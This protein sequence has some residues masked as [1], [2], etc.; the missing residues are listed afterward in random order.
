MTNR[1]EAIIDHTIPLTELPAISEK[2][3]PST[4][5][6][7]TL[8]RLIPGQFDTNLQENSCR[9]WIEQWRTDWIT[10]PG[11]LEAIH[12]GDFYLKCGPMM[13]WVH[14]SHLLLTSCIS[15][16]T[17]LANRGLRSLHEDVSNAIASAVKATATV[18]GS[19]AIHLASFMS[20]KGCSVAEAVPQIR[21]SFTECTQSPSGF[22]GEWF[23]SS[24]KAVRNQD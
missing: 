23:V 3:T 21:A 1:S 5:H 14:P 20:E 22:L 6:V 16:S 9:K 10:P 18:W 19:E 2:I 17:L 12:E 11:N 7:S 24:L 15:W 13:L 4:N 8:A